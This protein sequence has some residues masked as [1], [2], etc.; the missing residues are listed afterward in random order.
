MKFLALIP[1]L[2]ISA[3]PIN[4]STDVTV[5]VD[6]DEA[7]AIRSCAEEF[8]GPFTAVCYNQINTLT[9]G[10]FSRSRNVLYVSLVIVGSL[11]LIAALVE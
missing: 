3:T 5:T 8:G 10:P 11:V 7:F 4:A 9:V 1:A 6:R 2:L